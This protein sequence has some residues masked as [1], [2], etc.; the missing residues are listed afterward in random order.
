MGEAVNYGAIESTVLD[1][2]K[3]APG[4]E[5]VKVWERGVRE[6]ILS[7]EE[8]TRGV[9]AGEMPAGMVTVELDAVLEEEITC[10]EVQA[11]VPVSVM[12][13]CR[14]QQKNSAR[15]E[16]LTLSGAVQRALRPLRMTAGNPLGANCVLVGQVRSEIAVVENKPHSFALA[17]VAMRISKVVEI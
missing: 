1:V 13:L 9:A 8:L 3:V 5:G 16:A 4:L 6:A 15:S 2:L 14:A 11:M 17:T 7:G 12:V 10:G